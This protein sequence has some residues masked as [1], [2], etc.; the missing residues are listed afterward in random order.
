MEVG[1][2]G[3]LPPRLALVRGD[4]DLADHSCRRVARTRARSFE[5]LRPSRFLERSRGL[6]RPVGRVSRSA[7]D[8]GPL[9]INWL[10]LHLADGQPRCIRGDDDRPSGGTDPRTAFPVTGTGQFATVNRPF[11]GHEYWIFRRRPDR[12]LRQP[13]GP[14]H[15]ADIGSTTKKDRKIEIVASTMLKSELPCPIRTSRSGK[16]CGPSDSSPISHLYQVAQSQARS[17]G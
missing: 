11:S 2:G 8:R 17:A 16:A 3:D 15:G 13:G 1:S 9:V 7:G 6:A 14:R 12:G 5:L 4:L 10:H